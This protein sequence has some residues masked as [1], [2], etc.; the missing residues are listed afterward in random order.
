MGGF[1]DSMRD[2]VVAALIDAFKKLSLATRISAAIILLLIGGGYYYKDLVSKYLGLMLYV[3]RVVLADVQY[4]REFKRIPFTQD[5]REILK[6][7][8]RRLNLKAA[9]DISK[10]SDGT[11]TPWSASQTVVSLQ[12][13]EEFIK[14]KDILVN[15]IYSGRIDGC[16][17]WSELPKQNI[18]FRSPLISGWVLYAFAD[19]KVKASQEAVKKL[20]AEQQGEGWWPIFP[21]NADKQYASTYATAW[22]ILGLFRQH[23]N[24]Y[25]DPSQ[26]DAV[27]KALE[28]GAAWLSARR[29]TA[30]WRNYPYL[31]DNSE[32]SDSISGLVLHALDRISGQEN[33]KHFNTAWLDK[34][35]NHVVTAGDVEHSYITVPVP[36]TVTIDHFE[37]L[38]MPWMVVATLDAFSSGNWWQRAKALKWLEDTLSDESVLSSDALGDWWRAE[39]L[40][41]LNY[42][43]RFL[44]K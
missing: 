30:R 43:M 2:A 28:H 25:I 8:Q 39:V 24:G 32:E 4:G 6:E 3:P 5:V 22:A 21:A 40:Y 42:A 23:E 19:L 29:H 12:G 27:K 38:K 34:L 11:F 17:C 26:V 33:L 20:L 18:V 13:S 14:D 16:E 15:F 36:S 41:S 1:I 31:I 7:T 10:I 37:Q 35:P 44:E 9:D